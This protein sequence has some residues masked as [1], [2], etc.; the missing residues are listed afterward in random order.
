MKINIIL[1]AVIS[2]IFSLPSVL[3]VGETVSTLD[4][5]LEFVIPIVMVGLFGMLIYKAF[6]EPIDKL[7]TWIKE[8]MA[9]REEQQQSGPRYKSGYM[10]AGDIKFM[11]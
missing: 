11:R 7:F 5:I 1:F 8:H 6:K 10:P 2:S 3:A 9:N 4:K